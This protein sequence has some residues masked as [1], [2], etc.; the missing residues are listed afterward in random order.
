MCSKSTLDALLEPKDGE[1][2]EVDFVLQKRRVDEA[3]EELLGDLETFERVEGHLQEQ[4]PELW[5]LLLEPITCGQNYESFQQTLRK[6]ANS[7]PQ[8]PPEGQSSL[9]HCITGKIRAI[10]EK[11]LLRPGSPPVRIKHRSEQESLHWVRLIARQEAEIDSLS[12]KLAEGERKVAERRQQRRDLRV[13]SDRELDDQLN[14]SQADLV[15]LRVAGDGRIQALER[16]LAA[17][18]DYST[19]PQYLASLEQADQKRKRIAKLMVQLQLWIKKYDKFIGEPMKALEELEERVAGLEGWK[20]TVLEPQ[21]DQL[22]ELRHQIESLEAIALQEKIE[23]MRKLHAV[24]ILQRAWKQ[25]LEQKR[26]KTS[27]K[28]TKKGKQKKK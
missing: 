3:F 22:R 15:E 10:G 24:R 20:A 25:T 7:A 23:Q 16:Q 19:V 18:P 11:S 13:R 5:N 8:Q 14:A 17:E 27:K 6:L 12:R 28:G 9:L 26:T 4:Q 1:I 2:G 21:T